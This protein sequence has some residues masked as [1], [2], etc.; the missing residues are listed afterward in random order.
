MSLTLYKVA[1]EYQDKHNFLLQQEGEFSA[2][3]IADTM[4]SLAGDLETKSLNVAGFYKNLH[5]EIDAMKE[6]ESEMRERR[7][8]CENYAERLK[9][10]LKNNLEKCKI[11]K[12][13][14]TEFTISIRKLPAK[15]VV[16]N[17]DI[18]ASEF[19]SKIEVYG[20]KAAIKKALQ[21]DKEVKGAHLVS[22]ATTISIR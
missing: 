17:A 8:I 20:D 3:V 22:G 15:V 5:L 2:Q 12:I 1:N 10:Y 4:E 21:A 19:I 6:Y 13:K 9:E 11:T 7:K 14:G 16:D 18:L